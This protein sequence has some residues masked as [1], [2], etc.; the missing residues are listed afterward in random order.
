MA[1]LL[2]S[3][4]KNSVW[5]TKVIITGNQ[6]KGKYVKRRKK[7]QEDTITIWKT[8]V[9]TDRQSEQK[10]ICETKLIIIQS[11]NMQTASSAGRRESPSRYW[12]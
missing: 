6:S 7:K 4:L 12:F 9:I 5:K 8:G 3:G 10:E 1:Q 2:Q 11:K